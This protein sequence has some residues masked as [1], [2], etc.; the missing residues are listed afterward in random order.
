MHISPF[1]AALLEDGRVR[2]ERDGALLRITLDDP[3][4]RNAQTPAMWRALA[5]IGDVLPGDIAVVIVGGSGAAFSAGMDRR[6]FTPEGIPGHPSL[7]DIATA[8]DAGGAAIIAGFQRAFSW[9]RE[10]PAIT[11]S[12]VQGYAVG[13]GF[14]LALATDLM[15]VADDVQL[16][17]KESAFGLVPDLAGTHPLVSAVGY[18]RALE[19]CLTARPVG[20]A[21]AVATGLAVRSVPADQLPDA[22]ETLAGA[23]TTLA[24][25]TATATKHLLAGVHLRTHEQQ[26][27]VEREV[28]V[29]RIRALL[30]GL[31]A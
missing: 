18:R 7:G 9:W 2:V 8:D 1:D 4:R 15:V 30:A 21:E 20:A 3:D 5:H 28:Q 19:I 25:G 24:P 10:S 27:R 26:R 13:A 14:Q 17:M 29:G 23:L 16:I 22:A 12:A 11:M 6:M 31:H